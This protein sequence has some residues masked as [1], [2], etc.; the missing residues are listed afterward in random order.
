[1]HTKLIYYYILVLLLS[2]SRLFIVLCEIRKKCISVLVSL[3]SWPCA[4]NNIDLDKKIA[5]DVFD[6]YC[7][8]FK[9]RTC[10]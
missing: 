1:M 10:G 4:Y 3:L 6:S 7:S 2:Q 9:Q 5:F 8:M